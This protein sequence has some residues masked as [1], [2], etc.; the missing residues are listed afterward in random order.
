MMAATTIA[1]KILDS[2][3]ISFVLVPKIQTLI[4]LIPS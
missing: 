3:T 4:L 2:F 1:P